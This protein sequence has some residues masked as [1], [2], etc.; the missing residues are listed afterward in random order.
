[1]PRPPQP[2]R[3]PGSPKVIPET[4]NKKSMRKQKVKIAR[5]YRIKNL[6]L[7]TSSQRTFYSHLL[8]SKIRSSY[9][10][11]IN[12]HV[13]TYSRIRLR[14][15]RYTLFSLKHTCHHRHAVS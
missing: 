14:A 1:M 12:E 6:L 11:W 10:N 7:K 9:K 5:P 3:R 8:Y 2:P 15:M 4:Q 13:G